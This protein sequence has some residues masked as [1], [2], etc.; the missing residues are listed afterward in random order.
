LAQDYYKLLGVERSATEKE[1]RSAYRKLARRLHP[2]VTPGDASASDRFKKINEAYEILSD[3]KKRKDY[4]EFGEHW[5]HAD[6][7]RKS[8]GA[9]GF[10]RGG[11]FNGGQHFGGGGSIFDLFTSGGMG[12]DIFGGERR[13]NV[14]GNLE[15]TLD[16]AFHGVARRVTISGPAGTR[17]LEVQVPAGIQDGGRIRINPDAQTQVTLTVRVLPSK[18]FERRGDDLVA[19][20]PVSYVDAVLGGEA[21]VQTMTGRIALTIPPGTQNGRSFRIPGK[22]MP[23]R[24]KEG[25]GDLIARVRVTMPDK[26]TEAHRKLFEQLRELESPAPAMKADGGKR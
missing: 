5:R 9:G 12:R 8:G 6:E 19:E 26:I 24:G 13:S 25:F 3:D 11:G 18:R 2:D 21:E 20:V 23:K 1:I 22:G 16:D 4:D 15:V 17:T 10:H 14:E 7:L